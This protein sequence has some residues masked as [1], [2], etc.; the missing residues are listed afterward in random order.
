MTLK[1]SKLAPMSEKRKAAILA[2]GGS[3]LST[4]LPPQLRRMSPNR[5]GSGASGGSSP[6]GGATLARPARGSS[7]P[8]DPLSAAIVHERSGRRCELGIEGYCVGQASELSHR[9][10]RGNGGCHRAGKAESDRPSN[11]LD[12]CRP[13]HR[14]I[15]R[16]PWK[17]RAELHGWVVR[18][19][20]DPA[21][22][23]VYRRGV[24]VYLAD[25]GSVYGYEDAGT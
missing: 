5:S 4:F 18:H 20:A 13:C 22:V 16:Q 19:G 6:A 2:V 3:L 12:A 21:Q 25:D 8:V 10:A 7:R 17:V 11:L 15:T 14:V 1:R 23:K 24:W 9:V